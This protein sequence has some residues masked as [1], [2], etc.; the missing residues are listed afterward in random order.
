MARFAFEKRA[1]F[2]KMVDAQIDETLAKY[3]RRCGFFG[4]LK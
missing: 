3:W 1:D 2:R 4:R